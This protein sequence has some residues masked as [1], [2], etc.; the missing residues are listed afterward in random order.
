ME[1]RVH[2]LE[3]EISQTEEAIRTLETGLQNFVNAD[4]SQRQSEELDQHKTTH[5]ELM[6]EWEEFS[7]QLSEQ[8]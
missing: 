4:E 3:E 7:K 8:A 5:A 1:D 6:K 2:E